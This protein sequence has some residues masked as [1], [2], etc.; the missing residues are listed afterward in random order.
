MFGSRKHAADRIG[1]AH[2]AMTH[3]VACATLKLLH[4]ACLLDAQLPKT[5][6]S[7][8]VCGIYCKT[9]QHTHN[10]TV[11]MRHLCLLLAGLRT[12]TKPHCAHTFSNVWQLGGMHHADAVVP[13]LLACFLAGSH[14]ITKPHCARTWFAWAS[15]MKC[16]GGCCRR[17]A[18]LLR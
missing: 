12:A 17:S 1:M 5:P 18:A 7:V 15:Q 14:T 2:A 13:C 3:Q 8:L 10:F 4:L 11:F 6:S 16:G 9:M